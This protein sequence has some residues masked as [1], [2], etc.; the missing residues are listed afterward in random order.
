MYVF[1]FN[2]KHLK[3]LVRE[4]P[5]ESTLAEKLAVAEVTTVEREEVLDERDVLVRV[6]LKLM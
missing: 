5:M 6:D 1:I 2:E 4:V 3:Y